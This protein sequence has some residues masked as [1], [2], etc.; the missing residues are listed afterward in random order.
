MH[1]ES[2]IS[3]IIYCTDHHGYFDVCTATDAQPQPSRGPNFV[4]GDINDT[5]PTESSQQ[6]SICHAILAPDLI[7]QR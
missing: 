3:N 1:L 2:Q 4:D 5:A 6:T 7:L